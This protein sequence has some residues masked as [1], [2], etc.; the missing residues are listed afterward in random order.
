MI[1]SWTVKLLVEIR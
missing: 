1:S